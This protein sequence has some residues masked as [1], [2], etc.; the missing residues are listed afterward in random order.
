MHLRAYG[1]IG[2]LLIAHEGAALGCDSAPKPRPQSISRFYDSNYYGR[3]GIRDLGDNLRILDEYRCYDL[4]FLQNKLL[5][6]YF[7]NSKVDDTEPTYVGALIVRAFSGGEYD[8]GPYSL[9][10]S[11]TSA[12][13]GDSKWAQAKDSQA[14]WDRDAMGTTNDFN[15]V[16][17][18]HT[19]DKEIRAANFQEL[20]RQ[21]QL[22]T[23]QA[24]DRLKEWHA[25]VVSPD[26][27]RL[28]V[29]RNTTQTDGYWIIDN[30][31][32]LSRA[33]RSYFIMR[34]YLVRYQ[35]SSNPS[36][37]VFFQSGAQDADCVYI[38]LIAPGDALKD[39][40]IKGTED[41]N[42]I[43]TLKMKGNAICRAAP[44]A[45]PTP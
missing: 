7:N 30:D 34:N 37:A 27:D 12:T 8:R 4:T 36:P 25:L 33:P 39:F 21:A 24:A 29:F 32:G 31:V 3:L 13:K 14:T 18:K 22:T 40:V 45:S 43:I 16:S 1:W 42:G 10:L 41:A 38:K 44:K 35:H 6:I 5:N 28:R 15:I 19:P 26:S 2:L 20:I 11:R 23:S 9:F 17:D